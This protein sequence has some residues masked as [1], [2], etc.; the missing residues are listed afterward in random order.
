MTPFVDQ[1]EHSLCSDSAHKLALE[2]RVTREEAVRRNVRALKRA[3]NRGFLTSVIQA[4]NAVRFQHRQCALKRVSATD[5]HHHNVFSRK[6][7]AAAGSQRLD[8][9]PIALTLD[10]NDTLHSNLLNGVKHWF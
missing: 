3:S 1:P 6:V 7:A 5:R 4:C 9:D 8:R 2:I 10:Q